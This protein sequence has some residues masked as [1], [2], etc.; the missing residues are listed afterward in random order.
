MEKPATTPAITTN[1]NG[2][3]WT[4]RLQERRPVTIET[5]KEL[6][7]DDLRD[8]ARVALKYAKQK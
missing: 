7:R 3:M 6:L 5:V 4:V 1:G 8:L 2:T